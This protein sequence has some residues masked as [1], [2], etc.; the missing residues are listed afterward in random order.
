MRFSDRVDLITLEKERYDPDL[1]EYVGGEEQSLTVSA[2][3]TDMGIDKQKLIY[4]EIKKDTKTVF[5]KRKP[6]FAFSKILYK[7]KP[8]K[9]TA[10]KQSVTVF[11]LEGDDSLG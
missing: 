6:S 7:G 1:G 5:L 11:Y 4:G 3:V 10:E 2:H 8:Y 9:I